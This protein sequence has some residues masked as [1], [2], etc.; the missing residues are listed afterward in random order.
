MDNICPPRDEEYLFDIAEVIAQEYM[1]STGAKFG[2][3]L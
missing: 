3:S 2:G 1:L